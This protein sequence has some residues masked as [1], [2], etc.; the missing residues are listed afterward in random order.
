MKERDYDSSIYTP[1]RLRNRDLPRPRRELLSEGGGDTCLL[2]SPSGTMTFWDHEISAPRG[3][4]LS[5]P[6]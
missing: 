5:G 4:V 2:Q 6:L 3:D 1:G